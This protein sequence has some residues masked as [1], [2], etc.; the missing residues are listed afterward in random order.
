MGGARVLGE[1]EAAA[2]E[3]R[4]AGVLMVK[5]SVG[6]VAC[7]MRSMR[8]RTVRMVRMLLY[9]VERIEGVLCRMEIVSEPLASRRISV[10]ARR[11]RRKCWYAIEDD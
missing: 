6:L 2:R 4:E 7:R 5:N 11:R 9:R 10:A 3:A 1:E 8:S